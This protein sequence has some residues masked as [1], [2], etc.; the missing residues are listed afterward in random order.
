MLFIFNYFIATKTFKL[1]KLI[2]DISFVVNVEM[3]PRMRERVR[4]VLMSEFLET[5]LTRGW[6]SL[7]IGS[8]HL[9][10]KLNV[11]TLN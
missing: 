7:M 9:Q 11:N 8:L 5:S 2:T 6:L 4:V 10:I 3:L 1:I